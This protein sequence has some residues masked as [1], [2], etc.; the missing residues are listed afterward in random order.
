MSVRLRNLIT[1]MQD[2]RVH[3]VRCIFQEGTYGKSRSTRMIRVFYSL[4][5]TYTGTVRVFHLGYAYVHYSVYYTP[6]D[7]SD[8]IHL[9]I[10]RHR[11]RVKL[12]NLSR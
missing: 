12:T 11:W 2:S 8:G 1:L 7:N 3:I 10:A 5:D 9:R 4:N 6:E